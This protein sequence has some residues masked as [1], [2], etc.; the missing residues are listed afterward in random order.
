MENLVATINTS[1]EK[2][3][4]ITLGAIIKWGS[5][6][7]PLVAITLWCGNINAKVEAL[8]IRQATLEG[9]QSKYNENYNDLKN[10]LTRINTLLEERLPAKK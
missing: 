5:I 10:Q 8:D 6:I 4:P 7:T 3:T 1:M 9:Q 2:E